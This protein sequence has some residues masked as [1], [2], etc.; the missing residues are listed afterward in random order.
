MLRLA[1]PAAVALLV[2]GCAAAGYATDSTREAYVD[3]HDP[4]A[5]TTS[6]ILAGRVIE[7]MTPE[8]VRAALGAPDAVNTTYADGRSRLQLVYRSSVNRYD[9]G[10]VYVTDGEV[11]AWQ[12]LHKVPRLGYYQ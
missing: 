4:P 12:N 7:G 5:Q 8:E 10:Y 6:A 9:E 1:F 11:T 2:A 3:K